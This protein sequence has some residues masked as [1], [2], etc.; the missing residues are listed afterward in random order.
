MIKTLRNGLITFIGLILFLAAWNIF[1]RSDLEESP[2]QYSEKEVDHVRELRSGNFDMD[3]PPRIHVEVDYSRG[4]EANWYPRGEAPVLA[5]LVEEG[6]LPPVE[7][8]VGPEPAVLRGVDGIGN[9][10]GTWV[11]GRTS[12]RNVGSFGIMYAGTHLVRWSPLGL[13]VVPHVA[14]K[15]EVRNEG[16]EFVFH[17]RKGMRWSDGHPFT[18][19]DILYWWNHEENDPEAGVFAHKIMTHR[20]KKGE[21]KKIDD[22]TVVFRFEDTHSIFLNLLATIGGSYITGSPAHYLKQYHPTKGDPEVIEKAMKRYNMPSRRA[23]YNDAIKAWDNPEHPRIWPFVYRSYDSKPPFGWV[24]NPYYLAV[25]EEGNQ[26]PYLDRVVMNLKSSDLMG[27]AAAGGEFSMQAGLPFSEYTIL[28]DE[29]ERGDYE[30]YHWSKAGGAEAVI[31]PNQNRRVEPGNP[32][33]AKLAELIKSP[34]FRK[35]LSLAIDRRPIIEVEYGGITEAAQVSPGP[36]SPFFEPELHYAYVDHDPERANE[37]LDQIGLT[38]RDLEGYRTL[39]DGTPVTYQITYRSDAKFSAGMVQSVVEDWADVGI[40]FVVQEQSPNLFHVEIEGVVH[41]FALAGANGEYF[42]LI[43]P[44]FYVPSRSAFQAYAY[45]YWFQRGGFYGVDLPEGM[46]AEAPPPGHPYL[47]AMRIYDETLMTLDPR[48]QI[49]KFREAL[50]L[51]ADN[52]WTIGLSTPAPNLVAVKNGF[53]NVPRQVFSTWNFLTPSNAGYETYFWD[54]PNDSPGA[55]EQIREL[56]IHPTGGPTSGGGNAAQERGAASAANSI[57]SA[58]PASGGGWGWISKLLYIAGAG[59]VLYWGIRHPYVGKRLLL[60]I[61]TL[62]I[63]SFLVFFIIQLPPGDYSTSLIA[64][65]QALGETASLEEVEEIKEMFH[66]NKGKVERYLIWSGLKWFTTF[67]AADRGLLQGFLGRSMETK[68]PVSVVLGDRFLLTTLIG[69]GTV[70][71]TW[72]VALPIGIYSAVRQYSL[73][74]YLFTFIGFIGMCVPNFLLA[75]LLMYFSTTFLGINASGLFSAEY[76][77]QPEWSLGKFMDLLAHIWI[78]ILV[79][80]TAGTASMIRVMRGNLLD[81]LKKP[82]VVTARAKGVRPFKLIMKYPVRLALN[83]F[84]SGIGHIFPQI[85]SGGAIVALILSLP[86]VGPLLLESLLAQ[87]T[88]LAGSLLMILSMLG[89]VGTLVSDLLLMLLDP[90]IRMEGG[91]R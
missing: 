44:R 5:G 37:L 88:Y 56:M 4:A 46:G 72:V 39:P 62:F 75:L 33:E 45:S 31:F 83:P 32:R 59:L 57:Q 61:P 26:L 66:L 82:Y 74:D 25:D 23:L 90:R 55:A 53:R 86:T 42:P 10:G 52:L 36:Q 89:I 47:E 77:V 51:A 21:V 73:G 13:P 18:A 78:P 19:E 40:R 50:L 65:A 1:F 71:F 24:R 34:K 70:I 91:R 85:I 76:A 30:L 49:E 35:A 60:M 87:D 17:L 38:R 63:V 15:F 22:Y 41:E 64:R 54:N 80:G 81:E 8:R 48:K 6:K 79:I 20:G 43:N 68:E 67:D 29:R 28:M 27:I 7:E 2:R 3:N 69:L 12:K 14:K 84:I 16:R 11:M 58:N 9:Y